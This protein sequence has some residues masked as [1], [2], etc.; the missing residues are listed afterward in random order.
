MCA[1]SV[2]VDIIWQDTVS[3]YI[4]SYEQCHPCGNPVIK[5]HNKAH[6]TLMVPYKMSTKEGTLIR[7]CYCVRRDLHNCA[8][9]F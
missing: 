6:T 2:K 8:Y 3:K 7:V 9:V 4:G 1:L 5:I